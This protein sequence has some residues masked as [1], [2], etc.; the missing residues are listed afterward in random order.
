MDRITVSKLLILV[1]ALCVGA[2]ALAAE[3]LAARLASG[4]RA[5]ADKARD[6]D[7][8]PADVIAFLGIEPGMT[9]VDLIA[10]G[11]WYTEVLAEAVGPT[12]KVYAQNT[13]FTLQFRE[14]ANDKA[15]TARLADGRLPNVERLDREIAELGL[16]PGS[17]DA[18]ITALNFHDIHNGSGR[19]AASGFLAVVFGILEPGGVLGIIDHVGAPGLDNEKLHRIEPATVE[20]LARAAGFVVEGRSK[21]LANPADDHTRNVFDES[22]RGRTDRLLLKLRKPKAP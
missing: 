18:A 8:K 1:V 15:M 12:G 16:A 20:E 7:R 22:I 14:G 19:E 6:A 13:A 4:D 9:V 17:V 3:D 10:A 21:L 2:S 11:G 5:D